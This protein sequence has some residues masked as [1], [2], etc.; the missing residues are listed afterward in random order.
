MWPSE[1]QL[2]GLKQ[3]VLWH[4]AAHSGD[5]PADD[6]C[7]CVGKPLNDAVNSILSEWFD[8]AGTR[9]SPTTAFRFR[10]RRLGGHI[11]VRVF[12]RRPPSE[13]WQKNGDLVFD[14]A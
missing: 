12:Q 9:P 6:T 10:W 1:E 3:Y 14:D 5:C 4:G 7:T 8:R 2:E 11:H 13:T